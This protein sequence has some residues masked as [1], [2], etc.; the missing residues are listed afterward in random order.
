MARPILRRSAQPAH[1]GFTAREPAWSRPA[2]P[3]MMTAGSL[4][5]T[6]LVPRIDS[7][8]ATLLRSDRADP[9][10]GPGPTAARRQADPEATK[11]LADA[12]A[13]RANWDHFPGFKADMEVNIDGKVFRSR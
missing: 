12:R 13:A 11:L 8:E 4:V 1:Q 5:V 2:A 6:A 7:H 10:R 9:G 3:A